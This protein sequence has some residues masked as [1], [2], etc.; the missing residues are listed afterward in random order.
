MLVAEKSPIPSFKGFS[1]KV[2]RQG[3]TNLSE[4]RLS[5]TQVVF[6]PTR[7]VVG[8]FLHAAHGTVEESLLMA[9]WQAQNCPQVTL[10]D[11]KHIALFG[12]LVSIHCVPFAGYEDVW[13]Q[14]GELQV[15]FKRAID[16]VKRRAH[17]EAFARKALLD[18]AYASLETFKPR[19][20]RMP[21]RIDICPLRPRIL[22]QCTRDGVIRLNESLCHLPESVMEETLAH[23]LVHLE[24]F[25]HST[26]FWLRLTELLPD[27][28]P[29]TLAHYLS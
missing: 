3:R 16:P 28:L 1:V 11:E 2:F 15:A 25:N 27:W 18:A 17:V 22:G 24:H 13:M 12:R 4:R 6:V 7:G 20:K 5:R 26:A 9:A 19:L 23:E 10:P 29:R 8:V 14:E 21:Q